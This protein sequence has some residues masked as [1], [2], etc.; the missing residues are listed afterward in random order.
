MVNVWIYTS[1]LV[2]GELFPVCGAE[3]IFVDF[4]KV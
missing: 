2:V 1:I 3:R 4:F